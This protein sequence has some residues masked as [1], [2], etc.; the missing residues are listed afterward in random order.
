MLK[1]IILLVSSTFLFFFAAI[2]FSQT[3]TNNCIITKQEI[4][5]AQKDWGDGLVHIGK[6]YSSGGNYSKE[7]QNFINNFYAYQYGPVLFKPTKAVEKPFRLTNE[8]A[9]SYFIG[10]NKNFP[11][12]KGFALQP[13]TKV[14]FK[15]AEFF[16][17]GD[18]AVVMGKYFFTP[19]KGKAVE[20]EYTLGYIADNNCK[21]K[22]NLQHSSL[23][24]K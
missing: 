23:P 1:K 13:W 11:E 19:K 3:T 18:Y 24:S 8:G 15:N 20:V 22:I 21:L 12:D 4:S 17:H 5:A 16:I 6:V 7:T 14:Q 2:S 10:K 9:L